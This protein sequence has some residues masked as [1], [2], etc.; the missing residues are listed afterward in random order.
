M[1]GFN[2]KMFTTNDH[3]M[4][5]KSVWK[6]IEKYIPKDKVIWEAFFG[7]GRSGNHLIELGLK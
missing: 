4:T 1:A 7:D 5:P 6:A 2:Q 3:Y